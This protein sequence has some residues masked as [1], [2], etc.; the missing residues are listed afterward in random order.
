VD[1]R[2]IKIGNG[3]KKALAFHGFGQDASYFQCFEESVGQDYTIYSFNLPFHGDDDTEKNGK[4]A[5]LQQ[6][7]LFFA[8]FLEK[9]A[10]DR[11]TVIG[12]SIGA[13]LALAVAECFPQH[14]DR[15]VL[16]APDGLKTNV[17]FKLATGSSISRG[18]FRYIVHKPEGFFK[19]SEA[20]SS[21]KLIDPGIVKFARSQMNNLEKREKVYYTWMFF[22][23]ISLSNKQINRLLLQHQIPVTLFL[24]SEDKIINEKHVRFLSDNPALDVALN[25]L[26]TGHNDLIKATAGHLARTS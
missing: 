3:H 12:F 11:F 18:I 26:P 22:R 7:K 23:T 13:K 20:V 2:Y 14:I 21:L 17:W 1:L 9:H 15:L 8:A 16:I 19:F 24:G 4:P 10:L 25:I 6:L 5:D